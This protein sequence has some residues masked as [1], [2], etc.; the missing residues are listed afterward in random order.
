MIQEMSRDTLKEQNKI[1]YSD[2]LVLN[3]LVLR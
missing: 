2:S 3:K 1:T